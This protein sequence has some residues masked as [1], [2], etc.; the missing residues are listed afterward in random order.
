MK[1][2]FLALVVIALA[3]VLGAGVII[4]AREER[5]SAAMARQAHRQVFQESMIRV[6]RDHDAVLRRWTSRPTATGAE[7]ALNRTNLYQALTV[8]DTSLCPD[9]FTSAWKSYVEI[10]NPAGRAT[11]GPDAAHS[12]GLSGTSSGMGLAQ[13]EQEDA[14]FATCRAIAEQH[15]VRF[16]LPPSSR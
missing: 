7:A 4:R 14:A 16:N 12:S 8:I 13:M 10:W 2:I 5:R 11:P 9:D 6:F 1:R 3:V 15:G